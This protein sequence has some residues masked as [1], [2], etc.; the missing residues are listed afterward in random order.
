[1]RDVYNYFSHSAKRQ[2]QF[3]VVQHFC[4]MEQHKLLRPCQTRR[5]SLQSCVS[6]LIEQWDALIIFFHAVAGYYKLLFS[7]KIL[8]LLQ[9]PTWKLYFHFLEFVLPKFTELNLMFQSSKSS[10][11]CLHNGLSAVYR[12]L[13]F[14]GSLLEKCA[15]KRCRSSQPSEFPALAKNVYGSQDRSLFDAGRVQATTF[16]LAAFS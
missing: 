13:L 10:V 1:M 15:T 2:E 16:K 7:Q 3:R 11:H 12:E 5:L 8:S 6:R 4:N 9:N 14:A